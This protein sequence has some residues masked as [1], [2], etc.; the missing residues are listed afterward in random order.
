MVLKEVR[1]TLD[2][3]RVRTLLLINVGG[4]VC[5]DL[6][7]NGAF[8]AAAHGGGREREMPARARRREGY[9]LTAPRAICFMAGPRPRKQL[10]GGSSARRDFA[11]LTLVQNFFG[12]PNGI[13]TFKLLE[14]A[15]ADI[16]SSYL[17]AAVRRGR[18]VH[19]SFPSSSHVVE[20]VHNFNRGRGRS[21]VS[22]CAAGQRAIVHNPHPHPLA[23][24]T[25][26]APP[27]QQA[28][29]VQRRRQQPQA[30]LQRSRSR[31]KTKDEADRKEL[32]KA[33]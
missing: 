29:H 9:V 11:A 33:V 24:R 16:H 20:H 10:L 23:L 31:A 3:A 30:A 25:L 5:L 21:S 4:E 28:Q 2:E 14:G 6:K 18:T 32:G 7:L 27:R 19:I 26:V 8:H 15:D 22:P 17:V 1:L 13:G 12:N